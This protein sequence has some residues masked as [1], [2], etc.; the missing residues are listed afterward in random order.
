MRTPAVPSADTRRAFP[1]LPPQLTL[2][3][4]RR[5]CLHVLSSFQRTG[6]PGCSFRPPGGAL[7]TTLRSSSGEPS[8]VIEIL[9]SCQAPLLSVSSG[10]CTGGRLKSSRGRERAWGQKIAP[11]VQEQSSAASCQAA[12]GRPPNQRGT[13]KPKVK[14]TL[15]RCPCQP[16]AETL[17]DISPAADLRKR[18]SGTCGNAV[19]L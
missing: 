6:E 7:S 10:Y 13:L 16:P 1:P 2:R 4:L 5:K 12:V 8:K 3:A 14:S 15:P 18:S 9:G 17:R 11:T 19:S